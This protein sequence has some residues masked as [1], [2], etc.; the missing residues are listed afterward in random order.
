[1]RQRTPSQGSAFIISCT[2][3][4]YKRFP[5]KYRTTGKA[6]FRVSAGAERHSARFGRYRKKTAKE[7]NFRRKTKIFLKSVEKRRLFCYNAVKTAIL[8]FIGAATANEWMKNRFP[9]GAGGFL[10]AAPEFCFFC[11]G[12]ELLHFLSA[13]KQIK[14][15]M[16]RPF[17]LEE[18]K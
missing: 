18:E 9:R 12:F 8:H 5:K 13:K 16:Q 6:F 1:M 10:S 4:K 14:P 11:Q 17:G 7:G 15:E 2:F 3:P